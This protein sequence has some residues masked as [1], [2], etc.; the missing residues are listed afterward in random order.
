MT[1]QLNICLAQLNP[2][3]GDLPGNAEKLLTAAKVAAENGADL[4]VTSELFLC[5]YPPEDLVR[6]PSFLEQIEVAVS[7]LAQATSSGP[8][9]LLGTPWRDGGRVFN[10]ALLLSGG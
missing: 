7:V 8:A 2:I 4:V 1:D 3:V 9:I 5:G 6:R 10:A